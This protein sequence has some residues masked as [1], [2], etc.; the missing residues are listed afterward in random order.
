MGF[1]NLRVCTELSIRFIC[2]HFIT[3][4]RVPCV[5]HHQDATPALPVRPLSL[6]PTSRNREHRSLSKPESRLKVAGDLEESWTLACWLRWQKRENVL[7]PLGSLQFSFKLLIRGGEGGE[8]R[9]RQ[10]S[11]P[12]PASLTVEV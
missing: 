10:L 5:S 8:R 11:P 9:R 7:Q 6:C 12:P 2:G 4:H 3:R 1:F